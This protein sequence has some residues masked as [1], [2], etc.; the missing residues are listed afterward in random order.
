M[1]DTSMRVSPVP[2]LSLS[3]EETGKAIGLCSKTVGK[4]I[5]DGRLACVMVGTRRL[6][7]VTEIQKFLDREAAQ[8]SERE[9]DA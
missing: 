4:L 8:S 5:T 3:L 6:V 7:P 2:R 9:T 1:T